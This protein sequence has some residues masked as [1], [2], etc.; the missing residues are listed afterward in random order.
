MWHIHRSLQSGTRKEWSLRESARA[1]CG[2]CWSQGMH[3]VIRH[4]G[5]AVTDSQEEDEETGL[6]WDGG[7]CAS[8]SLQRSLARHLMTSSHGA[9]ASRDLLEVTFLTM[10]VSAHIWSSV[11][12]FS[13]FLAHL[14]SQS[15]KCYSLVHKPVCCCFF[16]SWHSPANYF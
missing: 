6:R 2:P 15:S 7:A 14:E 12:L 8:V 5:C 11:S 1:A 9:I 4:W 16:I 13:V 10:P 3:L